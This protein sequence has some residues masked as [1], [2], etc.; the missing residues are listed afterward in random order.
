[1]PATL[2]KSLILL[3][4]LGCASL[5]SG[6]NPSPA[7]SK[8]P[9]ATVDGQPIYDSDLTPTIQGQ[10]QPLRNQEYEIKRKALDNLIEQRLLEAAAK[11]KGVTTDKLIEQEVT[12]K[13]P[14]PSD[15]EVQ[16]YYLGLKDRIN[17]PFADVKVQLQT[18]LKQAEI[19]Q[20]RED[21]VKRLRAESKVAILLS[22]PRMEVG[23]NPARVRGNP[24]APVMIV[25]FS[26]YQCPY[27]HQAE[28]VIKGVLAKYGD[29]VALAYRDMPL[30]QI[31]PQAEMA[32][33]ASRC[34][35]EQ[36]KFWEYHDQLF[37][38]SA[39]DRNSLLGYART[40]KLDEKQFDSC[41]SNS[42]Y[43]AQIQRDY[44]EGI[45]AG[46]TGTPA[47][48]VNGRPV[49]SADAATFA[50]LIEEELNRTK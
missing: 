50:R 7:A 44:D 39:L 10:L 43:A 8:Q 17:R 11:K 16:G 40:L 5:G 47:F 25:E 37:S 30:R 48:Y 9:V 31:H 29:K 12:S 15:A 45:Q 14:D 2:L 32:A 6:Q 13:V 3:A 1:M 27:C 22:A 42:K 36:G 49:A 41:L 34:A 46:V 28:P 38:S 18:S 19:Q 21:Y 4:C 23:Y 24:K 26:D 35:G 33:Q 20:A